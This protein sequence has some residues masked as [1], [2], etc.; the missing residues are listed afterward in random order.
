MELGSEAHRLVIGAGAYMTGTQRV[1][2]LE[3]R[4]DGEQWRGRIRDHTAAEV[5]ALTRK[6]WCGSSS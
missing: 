2:V 1:F 3:V 6:R 5:T 4:K